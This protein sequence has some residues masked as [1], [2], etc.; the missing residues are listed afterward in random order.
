VN[1]RQSSDEEKSKSRIS[2]AQ[3][4]AR[5]LMRALYMKR[6]I[7][8][9][10]VRT[11]MVVAT[12]LVTTEIMARLV[13][14]D[15]TAQWS[16]R[17]RFYEYDATLGWKGVPQASGRFQRA[18]FDVRVTHNALGLRDPRPTLE[19]RFAPTQVLVLGDSFVWG[20]GV[21]QHEALPAQL[22][23]RLPQSA[24]LNLGLSGYGNDQELLLLERLGA[25]IPADW[26]VVVVNLPS[27][28]DNNT[29]DV[30][31]GYPKP[32]YSLTPSGLALHNVPVPLSTRG[33]V[34][35]RWLV[36]HFGL[37]SILERS[38]QD[39]P[40][41]TDAVE[42]TARLLER[43]TEVA[44]QRGART[45]FVLNPAVSVRGQALQEDARTPTLMAR[46]AASRQNVLDL[47]PLL[48]ALIQHGR[49]ITL[50][51]DPHWNP[52]IHARV[53]EWVA[54]RLMA[55]TH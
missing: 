34:L 50:A 27:D 44:Q 4:L 6:S 54:Q 3:Q 37:Y 22:E 31:Y 14:P 51:H 55:S 30:Q 38:R 45:L 48:R 24:V 25:R 9:A 13:L 42:L 41:E 32:Y 19:Q 20:Y 15:W 28:H 36:G 10:L 23:K 21:E 5:Q 7:A 39:P 18:G 29:H 8:L 1:L 17:S 52:S 49:A 16:E 35:R 47:T 40:T 26:V 2:E 12:V 33:Q 46:L 53:A 43:I 11:L